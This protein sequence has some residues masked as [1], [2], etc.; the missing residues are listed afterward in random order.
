[1]RALA[2]IFYL[3]DFFPTILEKNRFS[4]AQKNL[5]WPKTNP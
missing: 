2:R 5:N 3:V 1:M 4:K